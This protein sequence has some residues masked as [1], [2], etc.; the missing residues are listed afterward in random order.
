MDDF[1]APYIE[2]ILVGMSSIFDKNISK[3]EMTKIKDD[4]LLV[5][6][7]FSGEEDLYKKIIRRI[8]SSQIKEI[9]NEKMKH[10]YYLSPE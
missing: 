3:I 9:I 1:E 8:K 7:N 10:K 4:E 6:I 5:R 2:G